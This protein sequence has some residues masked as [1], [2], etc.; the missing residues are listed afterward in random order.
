MILLNGG[1]CLVALQRLN[2]AGQ[3]ENEPVEKAELCVRRGAKP[4][5]EILQAT[6]ADHSF[7]LEISPYIDA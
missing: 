6:P 3:A 2:P 1:Q 4:H 5:A 7:Q